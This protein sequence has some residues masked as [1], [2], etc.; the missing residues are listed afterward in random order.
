MVQH[1]ALAA[2]ACSQDVYPGWAAP[3]PWS[4][5]T[6]F[7]TTIPGALC[8]ISRIQGSVLVASKNTRASAVGL[9]FPAHSPCAHV[10]PRLEEE[11][12]TGYCPVSAQIHPLR[13]WVTKTSSS[14]INK[15]LIFLLLLLCIFKY[16]L[17]YVYMTYNFKT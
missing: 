8:S 3:G 16:F 4:P 6:P 15:T 9:A 14:R 13:F 1:P 17:L 5:G 2:Q 12:H 11:F 10:R 7:L